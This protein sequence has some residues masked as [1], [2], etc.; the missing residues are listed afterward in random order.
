[1]EHNNE[2]ATKGQ[3][4][5]NTVLG[6]IGTAGAAGLLGNIG[7]IFGNG[8]KSGCSEDHCVNRFEMAQQAKIAEL[9]TELKLRDSNIY[10][11]GKILEVYKYFDGKIGCIE[12]Q[13]C[14]QKVYNATL[15]GAVSCI[16][17]QIAQ[18]MGLTKIVIPNGSVCPGWGD[19]TV[20]VSTGTTT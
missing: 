14:E 19:A 10:T 9:E 11:D 15:N 4:N 18:L 1:M 16:Q 5:L 7:G 17:G 3:A 8:N 6:S 20:T 2:F 12:N 13:L